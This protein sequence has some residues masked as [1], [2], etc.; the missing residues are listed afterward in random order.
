M[1]YIRAVARGVASVALIPL[2]LVFLS[3]LI[4]VAGLTRPPS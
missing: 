3:L 1:P 4:V 2:L